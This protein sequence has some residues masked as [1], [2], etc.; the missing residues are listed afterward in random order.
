MVAIAARTL[1]KMAGR[2]RA[3]AAAAAGPSALEK[4]AKRVPKGA[5][6]RRQY[7]L[8]GRCPRR[9]GPYWYV[10]WF[11]GGRTRTA[12]IG[13]DRALS[14]FLALRDGADQ[15]EREAAAE[16]PTSLRA[17]REARQLDAA[18]VR[19][20][21]ACSPAERDRGE[22]VALIGAGLV[23]RVRRRGEG[24]NAHAL[25]PAGLKRAAAAARRGRR[26][27]AR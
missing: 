8:C 10:A 26:A 16:G 5:T 21:Q 19:F 3:P 27:G 2:R 20:E 24:L 14:R 4:T 22:L 13:S 11:A 7:V 1:H 9:H 25:T 17:A 6:I 18:L 12:Y 15:V 23:R